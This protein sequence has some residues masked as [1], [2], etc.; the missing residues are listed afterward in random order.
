MATPIGNL[1][2]ISQRAI[3]IL[4]V[5]GLICCEDT[6]RSGMLL[7]N[8]GITPKALLPLHKM[9]E[10]SQSEK[11]I[12]AMLSG[13][14]VA[15]ISDAGTPLISDP[16]EKLV[17]SAIDAGIDIQAIPGASAILAA[18]VVS[19]FNLE[20]WSFEG[21][22]YRKGPDRIAQMRKL[23]FATG[24][25]LFFESP[26]RVEQTLID[27]SSYLE[28]ERKVV[29]ARE[30]TKVYEETWRGC[31]GEAKAYLA[32][33]AG[34]KGE[35]VLIVDKCQSENA[36][37]DDKQQAFYML[38]KLFTSGYSRQDAMHAVSILTDVKHRDLYELCLEI[39][40]GIEF[41]NSDEKSSFR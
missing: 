19:G 3:E 28:P 4:G 37:G 35:F 22:F 33:K 12:K 17:I 18:L 20:R 27:L 5:C 41:G 25:S 26:K 39:W 21:F 14:N 23:K 6:R 38:H 9:N 31:L 24:V 15:L 34:I 2:D 8:L 11:I 16:G 29:I 1:K 40:K 13:T 36:R 10:A 32:G 7:K 30:L